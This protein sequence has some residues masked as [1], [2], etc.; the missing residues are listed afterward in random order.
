MHNRTQP[1]PPGPTL[2]ARRLIAAGI[3]RRTPTRT[4]TA[5]ATPAGVTGRITPTLT[6][7]PTCCGRTMRRDGSQYVC[8]K[9]GAWTD[10]T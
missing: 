5:V 6:A 8:R 3:I 4:L 10:A 7:A 2:P 1:H 9:C